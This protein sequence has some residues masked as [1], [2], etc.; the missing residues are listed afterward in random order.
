MY[1]LL[2]AYKRQD[3]EF[4][5]KLAKRADEIRRARIIRPYSPTLCQQFE[6]LVEDK[7]M[8]EIRRAQVAMMLPKPAPK[9]EFWGFVLLYAFLIAVAGI[10]FLI[11]TAIGGFWSILFWV[12]FSIVVSIICFGG[13]K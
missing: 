2:M 4:K 9:S 8:A 3:A 13:L 10:L 12:P 5:A 11:A 6:Y 7:E 1:N